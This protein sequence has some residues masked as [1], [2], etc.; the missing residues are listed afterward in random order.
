MEGRVTES[1][2][3][4]TE[5]KD[6]SSTKFGITQQQLKSNGILTP[7]LASPYVWLALYDAG[8]GVTVWYGLKVSYMLNDNYLLVDFSK[9]TS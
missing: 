2:G 4:Y 6:K 9:T 7:V 8:I 3:Q 5:S 1:L